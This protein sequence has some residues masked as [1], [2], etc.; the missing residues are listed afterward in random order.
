[1]TMRLHGLA[2]T[3]SEGIE[4]NVAIH[5]WHPLARFCCTNFPVIAERLQ[6][7]KLE[8]DDPVVYGQPSEPDNP[9]VYWYTNGGHW[10]SPVDA[11]DLAEAIDASI[12][13]GAA[14]SYLA[15]HLNDVHESLER[16]IALMEAHV[17]GCWHGQDDGAGVTLELLREF[18]VFAR[19]S[20]GFANLLTGRSGLVA[21]I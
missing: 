13:S 7:L 5:D 8:P 12:V 18:S 2:P 19:T 17:G 4:F 16:I 1:M 6:P 21:P 14:T 20:G 15:M 10:L 11:M 3:A 9:T